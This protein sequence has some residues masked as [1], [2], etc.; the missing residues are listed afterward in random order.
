MEVTVV[1][2]PAFTPPYDH[3]LCEALARRGNEVELVTS[4]FRYASVPDGGGYRRS[5]LFYRFAAGSPVAKGLQHPVDM[6]RLARHLRRRRPAVVHFQW[7]PLPEIDRPLLRAFPRPLVFTAHDLLPRAAS[8]RRRRAAARLFDAVDAVVAHSRSGRDRLVSE[9]GVPESKA[10]VIPHGSFDYL[11][12]LD[13]AAELD[14][15][16]G[17]LG[18]RKVV[19]AFGLVRPYKGIDVLID[20]FAATPPETVL[21][22]VGR[23]LMPLEP[24]RRRARERGVS[25]RVRF[26][27]RFVPETEVRAYFDRADLVVLP[28]RDTEQSGVL[29][30]ALAFGR[31]TV[32]TAIGGFVEV[33]EQGAVAL[34]PPG[35]DSALAET[36]TRLLADDAARAGLAERARRAAAG[37]YSWD[38]VAELTESLYR[39]LAERSR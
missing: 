32:A 17:E 14:P 5:E 18:G 3:S 25:E 29:F 4:P 33:G 24:L 19:L 8:A 10:F 28:Y 31:P 30:T 34:V 23:P 7:L 37:P 20:A 13:G 21:L 9:L 12:R 6:L 27:P 15:A 2:P 39:S 11:T 22:V 38:R 36:I 16:A 1:D 26:I 35:D